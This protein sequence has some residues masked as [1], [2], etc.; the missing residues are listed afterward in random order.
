MDAII[1]DLQRRLANIV[2]S[3]VVH[4]VQISPLRVRVKIGERE[5]GEPVLTG[6]LRVSMIAAGPVSEAWVPSEGA[7]VQ[8][9]SEGGDLRLGVVYPGLHTDALPSPAA[10]DTE[11]VTLYPDGGRIVYDWGTSRTSVSL[12]GGD[13]EIVGDS[14]G[15]QIKGKVT[16]Q[17]E[18]T[19]L[20]T[21]DAK[22]D[23]KSASN[24]ADSWGTF[25]SMRGVYNGH[26]HNETNSVT[27]APNQ[28]MRSVP[29]KKG[30]KPS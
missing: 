5:N 17:D 15:W 16:F 27:L 4:D 2:R 30:A 11:H 22:G 26:T 29:A 12:P 14:T 28:P 1:A 7:A 6:W 10:T 23:I 25:A 20:K 19:C 24:L 9:F 18:V 3:G 13:V 8:V 21:L